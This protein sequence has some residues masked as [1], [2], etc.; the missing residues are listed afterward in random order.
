MELQSQRDVVI[1]PKNGTTAYSLLWI[2]PRAGLCFFLCVF[3]VSLLLEG[4]M[5]YREAIFCGLV[6]M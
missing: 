6:I 4:K 1:E 2:P 5:S 3:S